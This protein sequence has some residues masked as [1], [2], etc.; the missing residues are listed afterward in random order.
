MYK[1][2]FLLTTQPFLVEGERKE[3]LSGY[4]KS[5]ARRRPFSDKEGLK[6]HEWRGD[7]EEVDYGGEQSLISFSSC[8]STTSL[9]DLSLTFF[10]FPFLKTWREY[11]PPPI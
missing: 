2:T 5:G 1:L 8:A 3:L 9:D 6:R 10:F 4:E 7:M 11:Q